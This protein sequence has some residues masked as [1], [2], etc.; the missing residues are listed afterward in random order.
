[1]EIEQKVATVSALGHD[2]EEQK[3][4]SAKLQLLKNK[5]VTFQL[6]L[7]ERHSEEKVHARTHTFY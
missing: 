7:Q 5:L 6:L 1:M 3:S 4:L 2:E